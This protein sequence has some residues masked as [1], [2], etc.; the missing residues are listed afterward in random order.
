MEELL[1]VLIVE[2]EV[3]AEEVLET[4]GLIVE[5]VELL[6]EELFEVEIVLK[7]AILEIVEERNISSISS[8]ISRRGRYIHSGEV[9]VE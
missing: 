4:E 2:R 6:A 8:A 7:V 5:I 1:E 3:N 9:M